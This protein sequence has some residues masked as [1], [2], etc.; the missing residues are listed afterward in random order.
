[1]ELSIKETYSCAS[2]ERDRNYDKRAPMATP[3][4]VGGHLYLES[5]HAHIFH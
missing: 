4:W 1:M 5:G 3:M 2:Q